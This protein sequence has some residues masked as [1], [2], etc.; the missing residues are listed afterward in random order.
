MLTNVSE[1]W[2][3]GHILSDRLE[4]V[5]IIQKIILCYGIM[6][7]FFWANKNRGKYNRVNEYFLVNKKDML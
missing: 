4:S 2:S 6:R 7:S 3:Y 1:S 5:K